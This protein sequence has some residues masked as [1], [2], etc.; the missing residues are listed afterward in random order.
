MPRVRSLPLFAAAAACAALWSARADAQARPQPQW[1]KGHKLRVKIDSS[2]QQAAIYIDSKEYGIQ[3][4]TPAEFRLPRGAYKIIVE[5]SGFKSAEQNITLS[6]SQ[7]FSFTLEKAARPAI[8]DVRA[9]TDQSALGGLI[10]VD[11]TQVGTVPNQVEVGSGSHLLEVK[12]PGF[13]DYRD[14]V[15]VQ[16]SERRTVV[17]AMVPQVKPGQL[18]VTCDAA[19]ADVYIDG[20]RRDAAPALIGD[21]PEGDHTV[22]VRKE[23]TP[24][25]KQLVHIVAGQQTKVVAQLAP[26]APAAGSLKV[27]SS[28]PMSNVI[29]DGDP[30]GP[31]NAEITAVRAGKHIVE[32][33]AD[34]FE[35]KRVEVDVAPNELRVIPIDL[36]PAQAASNAGIRIISP[37]PEVDVYIDGASVGKAPVDR[38]NLVAGKHYVVVHKDGYADFKVE[39][40]LQSGKTVEVAANLSAS[41][42]V[43]AISSPAGAE[44][45]IDGSPAGRTPGTVSDVGV[46]QHVIELK[47]QNFA[48]ARQTIN[49]G[50]GQ[51]TIVQLDLQPLSRGPSL[52]EMAQRQREQSS[53][54]GLTVDRFKFNVDLGIGA[55][56][57]FIMARLTTGV[58]R[59]GM[60]GFDVGVELRTSFYETD[61]GIRPRV[62]ILRFDPIALGIDAT[63]M[64]GG[65]PT[66]RN[67][68]LFEIGPILTLIAGHYVHI[69]FKPYYQFDTDRLCPAVQ[70][71][72][73]DDTQ[74]GKLNAGNPVPGSGTLYKDENDVCKQYDGP[75]MGGT[76]PGRTSGPTDANG[77]PYLKGI[78]PANPTTFN[79]GGPMVDPRDRFTT[80]RFFLQGSIEVAVAQGFSVWVL[81]EG[82]PFQDP[83]QSFTS[84]FNRVYTDNDFPFYARLG[85]TGKF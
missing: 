84:K 82:A 49:V 4:Y 73:D 62:Q 78:A 6:R 52:G 58:F 66:K 26:A 24:P 63:I 80:N 16:D 13:N 34:G 30:K 42:T 60:F 57:Y 55:M 38:S 54:G 48:D 27:I 56:A 41:G 75:S 31:A 79:L 35:P 2:P 18:L 69:N 5:L 37:V 85:I 51:Q 23:G 65:G 72:K 68:F 61:V 21:L 74:F 50:G 47:L 46:G 59:S 36:L 33:R 3:G 1:T 28:T 64:G 22:E 8:L 39:V 71:I 25:W 7:G 9:A 32:L 14:N 29:L 20:Q 45:Y 76:I 44:I 12:K 77:Q 19:G 67:G 10:A 81:V 40:D 70:D 43:R 15:V 83:R 11:G 53:F 17:V